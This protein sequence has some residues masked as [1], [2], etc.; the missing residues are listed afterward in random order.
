M[1]DSCKGCTICE[2]I[3]PTQALSW[4]DHDHE[5]RLLFSPEKCIGCLNC[6]VCPENS[7]QFGPILR[8][9]YVQRKPIALKQFN[10]KICTEC[11]DEFRTTEERESCSFCQAKND[12]DPMR[13]F[14]F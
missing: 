14:D 9:E 1:T 6:L 13:F 3:C 4:E 10:R 5:S 11:G 12:R 2:S 8:E 7:I